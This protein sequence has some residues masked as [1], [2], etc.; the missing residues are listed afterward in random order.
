MHLIYRGIEKNRVVK[1]SPKTYHHSIN[2]GYR[3]A[4]GP[5]G[6]LHQ[7]LGADKS[8]VM[9]EEILDLSIFQ[10]PFNLSISIQQE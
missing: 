4:V 3:A 1:T 8:A 9:F 7:L 5:M 2:L 10:M 6:H